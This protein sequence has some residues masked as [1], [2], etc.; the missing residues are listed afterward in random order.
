[1]IQ[2]DNA[3]KINDHPQGHVYRFPSWYQPKPV[4]ATQQ[5]GTEPVRPTTQEPSE[6]EG[7]HPDTVPVSCTGNGALCTG[8]GA[9][10]I[11]EDAPQPLEKAAHTLVSAPEVP[12]SE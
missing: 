3:N 8:N 2:A 5:T 4:Q 12:V 6:G 7:C 11:D 9:S 10:S 1:M